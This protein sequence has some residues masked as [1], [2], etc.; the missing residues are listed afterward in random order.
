MKQRPHAYALDAREAGKEGVF[1]KHNSQFPEQE[2]T[3]ASFQDSP[4]EYIG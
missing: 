4:Y 1:P 3:T 2:M